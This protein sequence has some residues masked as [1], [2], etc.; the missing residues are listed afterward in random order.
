MEP[1]NQYRIGEQSLLFDLP[2]PIDTPSSQTRTAPVYVIDN[3]GR[4][5]RSEIVVGID[6]ESINVYDIKTP[7]LKTAYAL[8]P[9]TYLTAPP[10]CIFRKK[11][12]RAPARRILYAAV[13]YKSSSNSCKIICYT[14]NIYETPQSLQTPPQEEEKTESPLG[15]LD[16][17]IIHLE[18][19]PS[20]EESTS[21]RP[22]VNL[23]CVQRT[24]HITV[25][26]ADL[27]TQI[28]KTHVN[29]CSNQSQRERDRV[30]TVVQHASILPS[31]FISECFLH[32][33][34]DLVPDA[35]LVNRGQT[36]RHANMQILCLVTTAASRQ[37]DSERREDVRFFSLKPQP[38]SLYSSTD[39]RQLFSAIVAKPASKIQSTCQAPKYSLDWSSGMLIRTTDEQ[40][41]TLDLSTTSPQSNVLV[42]IDSPDSQSILTALHVR[43]SLTL[44][45]SGTG[46]SLFDGQ[47][48]TRLATHNFQSSTP[49]RRDRKRRRSEFE[50][51]SARV[52]LLEYLPKV[53]VV[54]G[55]SESKV[56]GLQVSLPASAKKS[57]TD[58][59][60]R[61]IDS[62]GKAASDK[63]QPLIVGNGDARDKELRP[64][65]EEVRLQGEN[66]NVKKFE[67]AFFEVAENYKD[68]GD[69][70][71]LIILALR[72]VFQWFNHKMMQKSLQETGRS[73]LKMRFLPP[74]VLKALA[75]NNQMTPTNVERALNHETF[76]SSHENQSVTHA[77]IVDA[78]LKPDPGYSV[79]KDLVDNS[80]QLGISGLTHVLKRILQ[81]FNGHPTP[82]REKLLLD[83]PQDL[84]EEE[85]ENEVRMEEEDA[86]LE[87]EEAT[88]L[89]EDGF[90][91]RAGILKQCLLKLAAGFAPSTLTKAFQSSMESQELTLLVEI[92]RYEFNAG[93]WTSQILDYAPSADGTKSQD[94]IIS[95]MCT[96]LNCALDAL[97][98]GGLLTSNTTDD[99]ID[100]AE[101]IITLLRQDTGDVLDC[102]QESSY[103]QGFLKDFLRFEEAYSK[104]MLQSMQGA[105]LEWQPP[106]TRILPM[107]LKSVQA[108]SKTK[109]KSSGE[110]GNRG[111]K[112]VR[113]NQSRR[114]GEYTFETIRV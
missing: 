59:S 21:S 49:T 72:S 99:G 54:I 23:L 27:K 18:A 48:K 70:D 106:K 11:T 74:Q 51:D 64:E 43:S 112:E 114:I 98:T 15:S 9:N 66:R 92:L 94:W 42:Q 4:K 50:S 57:R 103:L 84:P 14:E 52:E 31:D 68:Q 45:C 25:L 111:T 95:A 46:C 108:P 40:I 19:F 105:G 65:Y 76:A 75:K 89:L 61:L 17:P 62:I 30:E 110:I 63:P 100:D 26:S 33:A 60:T 58:H 87:L 77:M 79:I 67:K 16:N 3:A 32:T 34:L 47:Y 7:G 36:A 96:L 88:A 109:T 6:G 69:I 80:S 5:K 107:G 53:G 29:Q 83:R 24:G 37:G 91:L 78:I 93:G 41:S 20:Y 28:C 97:G 86:T 90:S 85:L 102:I 13:Q 101:N 56:L 12:A 113:A 22:A 81:G 82:S 2:R 10:Q 39:L 104:T 44:L 1:Q 35:D 55:L 73:S 38:A 8:P 71:Y